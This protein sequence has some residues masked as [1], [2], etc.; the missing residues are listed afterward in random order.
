MNL[1]IIC[2]VYI[3]CYVYLTRWVIH[4]LSTIWENHILVSQ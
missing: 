1:Y 4:L 3:N 2:I